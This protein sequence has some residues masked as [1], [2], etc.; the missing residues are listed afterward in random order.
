MDLH[1]IKIF[2]TV[3]KEK[4]ITKAA[5]KLFISQPTVT[6]HLKILEDELGNPLFIRAGKNLKPTEYALIIYPKMNK[7]FNDYLDLMS[8]LN[9]KKKTLEKLTIGCSSVPAEIFIPISL[10]TYLREFP[11]VVI[12][13]ITNDSFNIIQKI[14]SYEIMLG[15]VGTKINNEN[16]VYEKIYEDELV[17]A[18]KHN[19]FYSNTLKIEDIKKY[20]LIL[21]EEGSGTRKELE[22]FFKEQNISLKTIK[23]KIITNDQ[24]LMVTLLK[25][26]NYIG[27]MSKMVA[28]NSGLSAHYLQ[29]MSIKRGIYAVYR[30]NIKLTDEYINF[31]NIC[32]NLE[33]DS[34]E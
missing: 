21:R 8:S 25:E 27:F 6:E 18:A 9:L 33:L 12:E 3:F 20:P 31:I 29:N 34:Y 4:S 10:K 13:I 16:L 17:I 15:L 19:L 22:K 14:I 32:K 5:E 2:L 23:P 1:K 30:K 24:K 28:K 26:N 11:D 7:F